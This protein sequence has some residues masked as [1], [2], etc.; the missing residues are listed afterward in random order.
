FPIKVDVL[1]ITVTT[2]LLL[3]IPAALSTVP[4]SRDFPIY[5]DL[6]DGYDYVHKVYHSEDTL[7]RNENVR[8]RKM[9]SREMERRVKRNANI[10]SLPIVA[11]NST[12]KPKIDFSNRGIE[13]LNFSELGV[14]DETILSDI[15]IGNFSNNKLNEISNSVARL[16]VNVEQ[17]DVSNNDIL[18]FDSA[19]NKLNLLNL[20]NNR[21]ERFLSEHVP[22]LRTL[23][24]SSNSFDNT[25]SINFSY[26]RDLEVVDLS[27]NNLKELHRTL[28]QNTTNLKVVNLSGNHLKRILKNYFFTLVNIETLVLA[29]ND[30]SDIENDTFAYLPNLQYLDLSH[31]DIDAGSV[32]ALQ[33]IDLVGLSVAHNPRLGNALQGFVASWSLKELDASGTGL[34]QIPAALAQSVHTLSI[35]DNHFQIIRCGDLDSYPLL[36]NLDLSSNEITEIEDDALG[37]K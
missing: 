36:Q 34:C 26:F 12:N 9:T 35:A 28:F 37:R 6:S 30:I 15:V 14:V 5:S 1:L 23:D 19:F 27:C 31:N 4:D 29:N 7:Y 11:V 13:R 32:R 25:E 21:V 2:L 16:L 8:W 17:L 33:G 22:N 20:S 10:E 3:N 18:I 24:L